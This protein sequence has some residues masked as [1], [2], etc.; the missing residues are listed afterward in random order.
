MVPASG[1]T[2]TGSAH[3]RPWST[4]AVKYSY[5]GSIAYVVVSVMW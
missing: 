1:P 4:D 3:V 5:A 2:L